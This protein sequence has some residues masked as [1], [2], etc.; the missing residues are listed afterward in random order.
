MFRVED[1]YPCSPEDIALADA[2]LKIIMPSDVNEEDSAGYK[3]TSVYFDDWSD[4][5]FT[6][7]EDGVQIRKKY[8]IRIYN[9]SFDTIKLEVKRKQNSRISKRSESIS[10]DEC[11]ALMSGI[12]IRSYQQDADS[13]V[14]EFNL[15]IKQALLRPKII[16]EYDRKAYTFKSGNVRITLDQNV[17]YSKDFKGFL[18]NNS[19][20]Y[21]FVLPVNNVIEVKYDELLPG[22]IAQT[23]ET[24]SMIQDSYSKYKICRMQESNPVCYL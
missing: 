4:S 14:N 9:D 23:L 13:P 12:P 19:C 21:R 17:R 16:V 8:R 5:S 6:D 24:G 1:K 15:G 11:K 2:K 22:F 10:Y 7:N 18:N 20:L 3:I